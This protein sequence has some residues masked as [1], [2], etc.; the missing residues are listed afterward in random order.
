M[1][2]ATTAKVNRLAACNPDRVRR[3]ASA[4]RQRLELGIHHAA[5]L[6][7][8][9]GSAHRVAI[10]RICNALLRA[11][12]TEVNGVAV[13]QVIG[14]ATRAVVH[15]IGLY[16]DTNELAE[17]LTKVN[18]A[19]VGCFKGGWIVDSVFSFTVFIRVN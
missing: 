18:G 3:T 15:V 2:F 10:K 12:E 16:A 19:L 1:S 14:G 8:H 7:T 6:R 5:L 17:Q 11:L 13:G 9:N 4:L